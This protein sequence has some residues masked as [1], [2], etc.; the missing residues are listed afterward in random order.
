MLRT[1]T[2]VE[3]A[4]LQLHQSTPMWNHNVATGHIRKQN[5]AASLENPVLIRC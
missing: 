3:R 1:F 2:G 4:R 5:M